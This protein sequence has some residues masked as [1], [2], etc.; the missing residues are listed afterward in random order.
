[1]WDLRNGWWCVWWETRWELYESRQTQTISISPTTPTNLRHCIF[2]FSST[3]KCRAVHWMYAG[4]NVFVTAVWFWRIY[5]INVKIYFSHTFVLVPLINKSAQCVFILSPLQQLH[6]IRL[7]HT[8]IHKLRSPYSSLHLL[9]FPPGP[10]LCPPLSLF[11]ESMSQ[12]LPLVRL[13]L[14]FWQATTKQTHNHAML[15]STMSCYYVLSFPFVVLELC[16]CLLQTQN[17]MW[18]SPTTP[19][20]T[21]H[22]LFPHLH[23]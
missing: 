21:M 11:P 6:L 9:S 23:L 18:C 19:N 17:T 1:M 10:R 8:I 14:W 20:N 22:P 5:T 2:S 7:W 12:F 3:Q 13:L 4:E 15:T 16:V